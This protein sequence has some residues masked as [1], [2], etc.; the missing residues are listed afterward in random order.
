MW[1]SQDEAS[2]IRRN[3]ILALA[4][5]Y[6][7]WLIQLVHSLAEISSP[8]KQRDSDGTGGHLMTSQ[9][10][11]P[12]EWAIWSYRLRYAAEKSRVDRCPI[13]GDF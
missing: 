4:F 9:I 1:P 2:K 12:F 11:A 10:K 6:L 13:S 8:E 3:V 7:W 5:W